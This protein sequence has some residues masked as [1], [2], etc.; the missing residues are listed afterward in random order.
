MEG[1][2]CR[3]LGNTN[4]VLSFIVIN[5]IIS[6]STPKIIHVLTCLLIWLWCSHYSFRMRISLISFGQVLSIRSTKNV[7]T[8]LSSTSIS[9]QPLCLRIGKIFFCF[10]TSRRVILLYYAYKVVLYLSA[11]NINFICKIYYV[12]I[13]VFV[14]SIIIII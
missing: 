8:I 1:K 13:V 10:C 3:N 14:L 4:Y 9:Y 2:T 7:L 6:W 12:I 5:H 11:L